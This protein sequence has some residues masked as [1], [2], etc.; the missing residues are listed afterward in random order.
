MAKNLNKNVISNI[1][2]I[3]EEQVSYLIIKNWVK[4]GLKSALLS[5]FDFTS[6]F[7]EFMGQA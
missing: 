2:H 1:L 4:F 3:V 5:I 7:H 6:I